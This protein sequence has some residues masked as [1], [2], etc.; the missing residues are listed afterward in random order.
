VV[1]ADAYGH[2][3]VQV[4]NALTLADGFAVVTVAEAIEL[5]EAAI[6]KPILVLQGVRDQNE[7]AAITHY[8]LWPA[9]HCMDQLHWFSA[10]PD[11]QQVRAWIKL[12]TGMGRLGFQPVDARKVLASE[13]A[14]KWFGAMTHFSSADLP[15]QQETMRQIQAFRNLMKN[16]K[17]QMSLANSAGILAW[18]DSKAH[19]ARPGIM[20]YGSNPIE[21]QTKQDVP[22]RPAMR[23]TAPLIASKQ[24]NAGDAIGYAASYICPKAMNVGYVA[25][26][27]GDGLPRVLDQHASVLLNGKR[28]PIVGRVSM[29]SIAIDLTVVEQAQLGDEVVLWGD[30]HPVEIL[31]RSANTIGYELLTSIKGPREYV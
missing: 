9:I 6:E 5:R 13:H 29:D 2:G 17:V 31:A 4:A 11:A 12:D 28:C 21:Q 26:G 22:L 25:I 8:Q 15:E 1:K 30:E 20:L 19:W 18:P 23:V 24:Y 16:I 14:L 27:Y 3:A 10:L 7:C